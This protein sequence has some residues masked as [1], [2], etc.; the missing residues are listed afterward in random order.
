MSDIAEQSG[1]V[2][3]KI[4]SDLKFYKELA[5]NNVFISL[6]ALFDNFRKIIFQEKDYL[7][8]IQITL[9]STTELAIVKNVLQKVQ[10]ES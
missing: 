7:S 2:P 1:W 8:A 5:K 4:K 3:P 6:R 9:I 10:M